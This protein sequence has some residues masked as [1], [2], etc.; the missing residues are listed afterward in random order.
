MEFKL[1]INN[2]RISGKSS[3]S[4]KLNNPFLDSIWA[5]EE[6]KKET[7]E[8]MAAFVYN[9]NSMHSRAGI[10]FAV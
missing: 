3:N 10:V 2:R 7:H 6:T 5:K 4:L 8:A 9:L 1:P